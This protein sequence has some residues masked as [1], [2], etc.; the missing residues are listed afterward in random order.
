MRQNVKTNK[1]AL[2]MLL[3]SFLLSF[4]LLFTQQASLLHG[5]DHVS[6]HQQKAQAEQSQDDEENCD[7]CLEFSQVQSSIEI[8]SYNLAFFNYLSCHF[9]SYTAFDQVVQLLSLSRNRD[10]PSPL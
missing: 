8:Q 9:L 3:Q 10:P 2:R 5:L 7:L 1:K 6:P 4:V